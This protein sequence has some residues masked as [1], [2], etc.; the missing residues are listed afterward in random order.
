MSL[1]ALPDFKTLSIHRNT[2]ILSR[3][4]ANTSERICPSMGHTFCYDTGLYRRKASKQAEG[5][6]YLQRVDR[7]RFA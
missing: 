6:G 3:Y 4:T 5:I 7:H 2:D 1:A